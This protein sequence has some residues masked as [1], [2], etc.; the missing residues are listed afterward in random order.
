M[1]SVTVDTC[2]YVRVR[3]DVHTDMCISMCSVN[4]SLHAE[5]V[6]RNTD[7]NA[8]RQPVTTANV[9]FD[10]WKYDHYVKIW[11]HPQNRKYI[12]YCIVISGGLSHGHRWRVRKFHEVW[13]CGFWDMRGVRHTYRHASI[14][15]SQKIHKQHFMYIQNLRPQLHCNACILLLICIGLIV[16]Y[17]IM[18][19]AKS[20]CKD[21]GSLFV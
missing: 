17:E 13:T 15:N 6:D 11:C 2:R 7:C 14:S 16:G 9:K 20:N 10:L 19:F 8:I 3:A 1:S 5:T 18:R 4:C 12:M 21:K